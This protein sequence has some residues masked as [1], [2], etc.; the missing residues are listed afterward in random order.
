M[1]NKYIDFVPSR[2]GSK[3]RATKDSTIIMPSRNGSIGKVNK[4]SAILSQPVRTKKVEKE[5]GSFVTAKKS[6]MIQPRKTEA[7]IRP[8]EV[9]A[10]VYN[11][12]MKT[13]IQ[14]KRVVVSAQLHGMSSGNQM[15]ERKIGAVNNASGVKNKV[16][17]RKSIMEPH[18]VMPVEQG[19]NDKVKL[20]VIEELPTGFV[21]SDVPKRPLSVTKKNDQED[22]SKI[23]A[24]KLRGERKL[25]GKQVSQSVAKETPEK[26]Q[27]EKKSKYV[28]PK[29]PFINQTKVE[30]RPLSKNVYQQ[31]TAETKSEKL[32]GP[33]TII[34]K[35]EKDSRISMVVIIILTIIIG[36]AAGTVAFLLLPR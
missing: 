35:P 13:S 36:A 4:E 8:R 3:L 26:R 33:V 22:L 29:S 20:G 31:R 27:E 9:G 6:T 2:G 15:A 10:T 5:V 30:K 18:G 1:N 25:I 32:S 16:S 19:N 14:S 17:T 28:L 11:E 34:E 24:R 7:V 12:K 23:K 21:T